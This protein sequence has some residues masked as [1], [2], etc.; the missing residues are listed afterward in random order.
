VHN[1]TDT[2]RQ[3]WK[4]RKIPTEAYRVNIVLLVIGVLIA[5]TAA[6]I[7][8]RMRSARAANAE[9]LGWVSRQWLAEHH[10]SHSE[11]PE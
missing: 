5:S 1:R 10:A 9:Q 8:P 11:A 3:I 4:D 2:Q 6:V 7:I